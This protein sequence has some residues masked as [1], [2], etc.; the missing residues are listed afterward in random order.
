M[1]VPSQL[2]AEGG[3]FT[4][5]T[6]QSLD[7]G[8]NNGTTAV[9]LCSVSPPPSG[10]SVLSF[11]MNLDIASS[12]VGST[13]LAC[14]NA[15]AD[16]SLL[17]ASTNESMN[18][19]DDAAPFSYLQYDLSDLADVQFMA[20]VEKA[21]D[22]ASGW[23]MAEFSTAAESSVTVRKGHHQLLMNGLRLRL[24]ATRP[25]MTEMKI[26]E[27]HSTL[28]AYR[29]RINRYPCDGVEESFT[30]LLRQYIQE[31]YESKYFVNTRGGNINVHGISPYM[32]P[33]LSGGGAS[34]GLSL[35]L[36][37][38]PTCNSTV[39]ITLKVDVLG[40]AGKLVMRYRTVFAAF[41]VLVV[42]LVLRKQFKVYDT[43]GVF[44]S[45]SQSMD[46]C[47]RTSLPTIFTALTFLCVALSK[48]SRGPWT[49]SWFGASSATAEHPIDFT[50]NDLLLGTSDPFFWFLVPL[51][52]LISV[53]VCIAINYAVLTITHIFAFACARIQL[54]TARADDSRRPSSMF[55]QTSTQRRIVTIG[56]LLLLVVTVIPYQ[57]AYLVLCIVQAMTSV[58]ALRAA[59]E[60][61]TGQ[62]RNLYNYV[63]A[64]LVL[65]L[66]ILPL[67]L[68]VLT[69]WIH[70]L[71]VQWFS[72][73]ST[74]HNLL[75]ILPFILLVETQSTGTIVPRVTSRYV[76]FQPSHCTQTALVLTQSPRSI[77]Y[78]TNTFMFALALYAAIYGVSHAYR[79]HYLVNALCAWLCVLHLSDGPVSLARLAKLNLI[80]WKRHTKKRP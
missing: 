10:A 33:P 51:F 57:F 2:F 1:P 70:N 18:A 17:P 24:P 27:V 64:T 28:F 59:Q 40:S 55:A 19:F 15:A 38:D 67:N 32:P 78:F 69:V 61:H 45:F 29:L 3:K 72:S 46:Q 60:T 43:T 14:K 79:L 42:A 39:K 50:V 36:W 44:I 30:P 12:S 20:V 66:W 16:V 35:Q 25:I 9:F 77:R 63:H 21:T 13:R 74:H 41:P 56:I 71:A 8:H 26:P 52:G 73:F 49:K 47:L 62:S 76:P 37:T 65:L 23:L 75:C 22:D 48:A 54:W 34:E 68:P 80:P 6:D 5:L 11:A 58:R 7:T 53:G 4:L 31:P